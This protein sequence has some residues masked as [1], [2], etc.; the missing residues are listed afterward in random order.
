MDLDWSAE[1]DAF[2]AEARAWLEANV[3]RGLPSGDTRH[4]F[5]LHLEWERLLFE[6]RWAVVSWPEEFGG[7]G[8]SLWEGLI[9]EGGSYPAA[10]PSRGPRTGIFLLAPTGSELGPPTQHARL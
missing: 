2:R 6:H 10:A 3:P 1:E 4:G 9:S 5:A 8:A 7:R